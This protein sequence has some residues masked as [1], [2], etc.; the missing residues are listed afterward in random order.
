MGL[1]ADKLN[2]T[3]SQGGQEWLEGWGQGARKGWGHQREGIRMDYYM[4]SETET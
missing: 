1:Q 3:G 2:L 4:K